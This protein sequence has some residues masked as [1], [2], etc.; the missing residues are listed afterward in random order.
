MIKN[1]IYNVLFNNLFILRFRFKKIIFTEYNHD[2]SN[3]FF[4]N[5]DKLKK[6]LLKDLDKVKIDSDNYFYYHSLNWLKTAKEIGGSKLVNITRDKILSWGDT[7]NNLLFLN[8]SEPIYIAQ[9]I[10]NLIYH[11]DFFG[12]SAHQKDKIKLNFII[13]TH[14]MYLKNMNSKKFFGLSSIEIKKA[15][16]LFEAINKLS[17]QKI[18]EKIK[19]NI[20]KEINMYGV[21]IS[22][23]PQAHAEYINHLIEIKNILLYFKLIVPKEIDFQIINMIRALKS[24]IHKDGSLAYFNGSNNYYQKNIKKILLSNDEIIS[25]NLINNKNGLLVFENKSTKIIF[26][27]VNPLEASTKYNL[28]SS[29]LAFEFSANKEKIISNCGAL[30]IKNSKK[31]DYL[32]YSA[33]HSTIILNNTNISEIYGKNSFKRSPSLVNYKKNEESKKIIWTASHDG[34]SKNFKKAIKRNIIIDK[35]KTNI[36]GK[37]EIISLGISKEKLLFNCR[38]HLTPICK[39]LLTRG[40]MSAIIKT[41]NSSYLFK[42]DHKIAIEESI[43]INDDDKIEKTSQIVISGFANT[44]KKTINWSIS[45]Y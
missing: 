25:K 11:Y 3:L 13:F 28:H 34:Y 12:T 10:I 44:S 29:T 43:Y 19:N 18:I 37:D 5:Q 38:F 30:N 16:L 6:I 45:K 9:R 4:I 33:A 24:F 35:F 1:Y 17:I 8:K 42:S 22:M 14:Y 41:I 20:L 15:I 23:N 21:H 32:R 39:A 31:P 36:T 7:Y 2:F 40:Q 27:T 26:D